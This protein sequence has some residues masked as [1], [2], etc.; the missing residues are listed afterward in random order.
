MLIKKK[1]KKK[2][3]EIRKRGREVEPA[4]SAA[5]QIS[6]HEKMTA[7]ARSEVHLKYAFVIICVLCSF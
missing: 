2:E 6:V 5:G 1:V 3:R 7:T 4:N